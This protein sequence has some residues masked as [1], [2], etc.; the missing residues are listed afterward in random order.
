MGRIFNRGFKDYINDLK[1][2][3]CVKS[4]VILLV[5]FSFLIETYSQKLLNGDF[6]INL[7]DTCQTN[8][9]NDS[10]S[11][12]MENVVAFGNAQCVNIFGRG[13][14]GETPQQGN[15]CIGLQMTGRHAD[16][17]SMKFS[18][19]LIKGNKYS[20][21]FYD[22]VVLDADSIYIGISNSAVNS[23]TVIYKSYPIWKNWEK[24][25][26]TFI[27]PVSG[28]YITLSMSMCCHGWINFDNFVIIPCNFQIDVRG[29]TFVCSGQTVTLNA[30]YPGATYLWQDGSQN[31]SLE[32][33]K[34]GLYKVK[35]TYNGCSDSDSVRV[36]FYD[37]GLDCQIYVPDIFSPNQ[38]GINDEFNVKTFCYIKDY[39]IIIYDRWGEKI[40]EGSDITKN[41]DGNR[42]GKPVEQGCYYYQITAITPIKPLNKIGIIHLLR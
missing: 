1:T 28:D 17:I 18:S 34:D 25:S 36:N 32:V 4:L 2:I 33:D 20:L 10:F 13:C 37:C 3:P 27:A 6:E 23:G 9:R 40:Y 26:F 12:I 30:A 35:V 8:L 31:P 15:W 38:D 29:D 39:H 11:S 19:G 14:Y 22:R 16:A 24:E 7:A 5:C 21:S 41:W 42:H